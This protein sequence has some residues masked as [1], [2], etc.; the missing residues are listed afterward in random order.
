[1]NCTN[2]WDH[3]HFQLWQVVSVLRMFAV[4]PVGTNFFASLHQP[5]CD[6]CLVG[7]VHIPSS[8]PQQSRYVTCLDQKQKTAEVLILSDDIKSR[9]VTRCVLPPFQRE[10]VL[11]EGWGGVAHSHSK[12]VNR[13]WLWQI[14]D[15]WSYLLPQINS[16]Y[17]DC[18]THLPSSFGWTL[19]YSFYI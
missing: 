7:G 6:Y 5:E 18:S 16:A 12:S 4:P 11:L 2:L 17:T 14:T 1:M 19:T 9:H 15:L 13:K 3:P 10:M 8:C